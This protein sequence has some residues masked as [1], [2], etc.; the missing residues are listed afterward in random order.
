MSLAGVRRPKLFAEMAGAIMNIR[1]IPTNSVLCG[2]KGQETQTRIHTCTPHPLCQVRLGAASLL[3]VFVGWVLSRGTG[4]K[5]TC[6]HNAFT[7][8]CLLLLAPQGK[9]FMEMAVYE[10]QRCEEASG[11][12]SFL[13]SPTVS[14]PLRTLSACHV[15]PWELGSYTCVCLWWWILKKKQLNNNFYLNS[16]IVL[17]ICGYCNTF[18]PE[19]AHIYLFTSHFRRQR[20]PSTAH[21][22][23][24]TETTR[25]CTVSCSGKVWSCTYL[26][27]LIK[28]FA[29]NNAKM[30]TSPH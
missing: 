10:G 24:H 21:Q 5:G 29:S 18:R 25:N 23:T 20:N 1:P 15:A 13:E 8:N 6:W 12:I 7:N 16:G 17:A 22:L 28:C 4:A 19:P 9:H 2:K 3:G 14:N 30:T 27:T 11:K 26:H